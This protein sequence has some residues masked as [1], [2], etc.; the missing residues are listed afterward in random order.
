MNDSKTIIIGGDSSIATDMLYEMKISGHTCVA[1]S[2]RQHSD[3]I[4]CDLAQPDTWSEVL[5]IVHTQGIECAI[6]LAAISSVEG[7]VKQSSTAR[8]VNYKNTIRLI[9]Q[10]DSMGVFTVFL[11]TNHVFSDR[12]PMVSWSSKLEPRS[13]YGELKAQVEA[14]VQ[15]L[16]V[17]IVR[18]TKIITRDFHVFEDAISAIRSGHTFNAFSDHNMAPVSSRFLYAYVNEI[19]NE[20]QAGIYQL[21]GSQD[22]SYLCVIKLLLKKLNLPTTLLRESFAAIKNVKADKFSSLL[23]H[24]P[25]T[26]KATVQ[27]IECVLDDYL[28]M[29]NFHR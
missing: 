6:F 27:P 11:S 12:A 8:L 25:I 26:H 18:P 1:T 5:K 14:G 13:Y 20:K 28:L 17:A 22:V 7:C 21:S 4:Y 15:G 16:D 19:V 3:H 29:T 2:R 9:K 23:P 24:S 10:L